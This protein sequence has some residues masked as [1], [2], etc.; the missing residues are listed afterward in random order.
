MECPD[1]RERMQKHGLFY[2]CSRCGLSLKPWEVQKAQKRAQDE[3]RELE[4][5][6]PERAKEKKRKERLRYRNWYEGKAEVD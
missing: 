6:D 2:T 4:N 3:V 5:E 1:C